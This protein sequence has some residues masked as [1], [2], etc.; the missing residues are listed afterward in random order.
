MSINVTVSGNPVCIRRRRMVLSDLDLIKQNERDRRRRLRLEQVR[1][2]SKEISNRLLE[3]AK[4][5]T[6]KEL[7]KLEKDG[8]SELRQAHERKILE[9]QSKYQEEMEDIGMAH[10]SAALQADV[11]ATLEAEKK[12]NRAIA[13]ERG[14][15][16][17]QR[18]KELSKK[19]DPHVAQQERLRQVREIENVRSAM[20]ANLPNKGKNPATDSSDTDEMEDKD[21]NK[22][23][24]RRK[25][26]PK[27]Q[28][29]KQTQPVSAVSSKSQKS[30]SPLRNVIQEKTPSSPQAGPSGLQKQKR[31]PERVQ[32]KGVTDI[33]QLPHTSVACDSDEQQPRKSAPSVNS[34]LSKADKVARYN[35]DDYKQD[36][37]SSSSSLSDDSSY[38]SDGGSE[39]RKTKK[40]PK[41]HTSIASS[42]VQ[43]Y[44]HSTRQRNAYERPVGLVERVDLTNE[45][46]A[47]D[48]AREVQESESVET[49]L[50]ESRRLTAQ[51]RGND[52]I[53]RERVRRDYQTLIENMDHLSR[54][55]RK[56]RASQI[57]SPPTE[58]IHMSQARRKECQEKRQ[59]KMDRAFEEIMHET[60]EHHHSPVIPERVITLPPREIRS[61]EPSP[62]WE[63]A[64]FSEKDR[65]KQ[66]NEESEQLSREEQILEML[67]KVERQK[68]LLLREFG[69]NLPNEVL[70]ASLRPL[71]DEPQPGPSRSLSRKSPSK[72]SPPIKP[73]SP[74][75]KVINLSNPEECCK[76]EKK[77]QPRKIEIAIQT[78]TL[79]QIGAARD[80]SVQVELVPDKKPTKENNSEQETLPGSS[81]QDPQSRHSSNNQ[82]KVSLAR[83]VQDSSSSGSMLTG[84]VIDIDKEYVRVTPKKKKC[85]K[86]RRSPRFLA[87]AHSTPSSKTG[88][89]SKRAARSAPVT[90]RKT[91]VKKTSLRKRIDARI[92]VDSSTES[93]QAYQT[94]PNQ[95]TQERV[96]TAAGPAPGPSTTAGP[97]RLSRRRSVKIRETSD[98]STSYASPPPSAPAMLARLLNNST[99]ILELLD[100]SLERPPRRL[101]SP[102]SSPETPS[103]RTMM[104]PSNVPRPEHFN[105]VLQYTGTSTTSSQTGREDRSTLT[106][107]ISTQK[108]QIRSPGRVRRK[109]VQK[110]RCTCRNPTCTLIHEKLEAY[111]ET[112]KNSPEILKKYDD[113]QHMCTERIAS[114]SD[115]IERVR[116]DQRGMEFSLVTPSDESSFMQFPPARPMRSDLYS[117][118]RLVDSIE[119][120][121]SQLAQTLMDS[122]RIIAGNKPLQAAQ[123]GSFRVTKESTSTGTEEPEAREQNTKDEKTRAKPRVISDEPINLSP[124]RLRALKTPRSA[125]IGA[126]D[127]PW[128][129]SSSPHEDMVK[130]LSKEILEQSKSLNKSEVKDEGMQA[131]ENE[132]RKSLSPTRPPVDSATVAPSADENSNPENRQISWN[133][134]S[135]KEEEFVPV[136]AGIP[137]VSRRTSSCPEEN[138]RS[139][140]GRGKPP[141]TLGNNGYRADILVSP[142]HDLSTIVELDTPDTVNKSQSSV[143]SP[144]GKSR[145]SLALDNASQSETPTRLESS[146][147]KS[148]ES[149]G[150]KTSQIIGKSSVHVAPLPT[151]KSPQRSPQDSPQKNKQSSPTTSRRMSGG[152]S[153]EL[154]KF[155]STDSDRPLTQVLSGQNIRQGS[156]QSDSTSAANRENKITSTSFNSFSALSGISEITSTP[157]SDVLKYASTLEEMEVTLKKLGLGWAATT[158]KKTREASALSSSSNSDV[159]PMNTARR[160]MSPG[161]KSDVGGLPDLSDV[162]SI[163]I[164]DASKSTDRAV[165]LRG[166]TSTPNIQNSNSSSG[167]SSSCT[168]NSPAISLQDASDSLT[169]PN[170]SL[171]SKK[172]TF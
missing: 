56:L 62:V 100:S 132:Q 80:Q 140:N 89:P 58:D 21:S 65:G 8:K 98:T 155:E 87:K 147:R 51:R 169:A 55:E 71:F 76:K 157:S 139:S 69:A 172:K 160:M 59:R 3:R 119:A 158:L 104:L 15:E 66:E 49:Q 93:S 148:E 50:A 16:A 102:V 107:T 151:E 68:R 110:Q 86:A 115:L 6:Q 34:I 167:K 19:E 27:V 24:E 163:S 96:S 41:H 159:T 109:P 7:S 35:P 28:Q 75:I 46:N 123:P 18:T 114:L 67:K 1:Q 88:S 83:P 22:L 166:R 85:T 142:G 45:P 81:S 37:S 31:T 170:I 38:F 116:N 26:F 124:G 94:P 112:I 161:L 92:Q 156:E 138:Q 39:P 47:E 29:K 53:L 129:T 105:M 73:P 77:Q 12:K 108:N 106:E 168:S 121:H 78:S 154:S 99:P 165:L 152:G 133:F 4:N 9:L 44:D 145:R 33:S 122:E 90:P 17:M 136:L 149:Q 20:V 164:K 141:V 48:L 103:P 95:Q 32:S 146:T 36:S 153:G 52:A 118:R 171:T 135:T 144:T 113:L 162:S 74:E 25:N 40:T 10:T 111:D 43:V 70:N 14:R 117:V 72:K 150:R 84:V 82:V 125:P 11:F 5:L 60:A 91:P 101:V 2:Q 127:A 23:N 61:R 131:N 57:H 126:A 128:P 64:P 63:D 134:T 13:M 30:M 97:I 120:I 42:K 54:E 79:E 137:K 143:R 130:K